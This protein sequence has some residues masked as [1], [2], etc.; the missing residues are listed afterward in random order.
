MKQP[1]S[2]LDNL[3]HHGI[4]HHVETKKKVVLVVAE[5]SDVLQDERII[6]LGINHALAPCS[7]ET[8][9]FMVGYAITEIFDLLQFLEDGFLSETLL[10]RC[11]YLQDRLTAKT[12]WNFG[13]HI[14][15]EAETDRC[16]NFVGGIFAFGYHRRYV[17]QRVAL[18]WRMFQH[19]SVLQLVVY[20]IG[21]VENGRVVLVDGITKN[22][23]ED[24]QHTI[25]L[26]TQFYVMPI[27]CQGFVDIATAR[28]LVFVEPCSRKSILKI[29]I[30][31]NFFA[32]CL[33]NSDILPIFA[34]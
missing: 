33:H 32:I 6:G 11:K 29:F 4:R 18:M 30:F 7:I 3:V 23:F 20:P 10:T 9:R 1:Q 25:K 19:P 14:R 2:Q 21:I 12:E 13:E 24:I 31:H 5:K 34:A 17:I 27:E 26:L 16:D 15:P 22:D 8:D 28:I